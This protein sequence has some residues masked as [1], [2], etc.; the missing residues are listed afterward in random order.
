MAAAQQIAVPPQH[1]VRRDDQLELT[2][3]YPGEAVQQRSEQYP[4]GPGELRLLHLP[5]KYGE[6]VAQREDLEVLL[7]VAHRQ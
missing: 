2:K 1:G 5:L 3:P 7:T 4:L 6:L